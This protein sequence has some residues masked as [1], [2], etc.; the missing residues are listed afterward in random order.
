MGAQNLVPDTR[1]TR[2]RL[3]ADPE[4]EQEDDEQERGTE[5]PQKDQDHFLC[6]L[7]QIRVVRSLRSGSTRTR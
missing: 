4:Q 3:V 7:Y 2:D 5:Q 6:L 1:R